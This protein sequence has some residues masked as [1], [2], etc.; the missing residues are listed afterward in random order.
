MAYTWGQIRLLIQY[1]AGG[2]SLDTIDQAINARYG[3]ILAMRDWEGLEINATIQTQDAYQVGSVAVIQGSTAVVG[4]GTTWLNGMSGEQIIAGGSR[5]LYTVTIL[6]ATH[7]TLDRPFEGPSNTSTNYTLLQA[8]VQLPDDCRHLRLITSP[9]TGLE[10]TKMTDLEFAQ[11]VGFPSYEGCASSYIPQ[12][13]GINSTS[14]APV[15]QLLLYPLP[16]FTQGYPITYE[17]VAIAFDGTATGEGP[18]EFVSGDAIIA[19]C[20]LDLGVAKTMMDVQLLQ[21]QWD[22]HITGMN[23]IENGQR[24]ARP[25]QLDPVYTRHRMA[26]LYR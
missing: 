13:D 23:H 10:L 4:T 12:P 16:L 9:A 8:I 19:G 22:L 2:V 26:R 3:A 11:Q 20:K 6:D 17:R 25:L 24:A 18:L 7:A 21:A 5:A 14:G 1:A 15:K